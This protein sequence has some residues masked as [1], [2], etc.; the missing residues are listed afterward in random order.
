MADKGHFGCMAL[1]PVKLAAAADDGDIY[2]PQSH[3][4]LIINLSAAEDNV[5]VLAA[6][7]Y[8]G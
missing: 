3:Q 2:R 6:S 4:V 7:G 1:M 8:T 5:G